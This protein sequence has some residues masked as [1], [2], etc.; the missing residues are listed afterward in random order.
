M[1]LGG[2]ECDDGNNQSSDGCSNTCEEEEGFDCSSGTCVY[3]INP[4]L[5]LVT[6]SGDN[7][8]L[9]LRFSC[10]LIPN[11][12]IQKENFG[13]SLIGEDSDFVINWDF[14]TRV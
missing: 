4:I 11:T 1:I 8:L 2:E 14:N 6:N 7:R 13:I 3:E 9:Q 12:N 5:N 10:T